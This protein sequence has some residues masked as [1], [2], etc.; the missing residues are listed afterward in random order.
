M[1]FIRRNVNGS[2]S[3]STGSSG[4]GYSSVSGGN[5]K[6]ETHT[7]FSQPFDGTNDVK[8]DLA[9]VDKITADGDI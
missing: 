9:D 2:S 6:L 8:G 3:T 7:I 1:E 5:G 4:G